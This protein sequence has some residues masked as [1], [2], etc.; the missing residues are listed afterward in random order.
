MKIV[1]SQSKRTRIAAAAA[2][3]AFVPATSAFVTPSGRF[4]K[5]STVPSSTISPTLLMASTLENPVVTT[6]STGFGS[7]A[8]VDT[9]SDSQIINVSPRKTLDVRI[10]GT[11]YDL[12]GRY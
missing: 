9:K 10:H 1:S 2:V 3:A 7:A 4:A 12:T 6:N 8:V 11:W 5:I